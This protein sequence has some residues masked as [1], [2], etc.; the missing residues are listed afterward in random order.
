MQLEPS[1]PDPDQSRRVELILEQLDA[2]PTLSAV[3]VQV[4]ELTSDESSEMREVIDVISSDP[5]LASKVLKLCRCSEKGRLANVTTIDRAVVLLGF[6]SV[7]SAVLSV[8]VFELLEGV[9]S[10][11]GELYSQRAVFDRHL[12]WQHSLAVAITAERLC[13][14]SPLRKQIQPGEAFICGLLHDLGQLCLHLIL[15]KSFDR[16]CEL[17]VAQN[18]PLDQACLQTLGVDTHT[19]SRRVAELWQLPQQLSDVMWLNGQLYESLPQLDHR[20]LVGLIS[21]A[22]A[23]VRREH[24]APLGHSG[25]DNDLEALCRPLDVPF[26]MINDLVP[27]LREELELRSTSLGLNSELC[28]QQLLRSI[29]RANE[30]LGRTN[31]LLRAKSESAEKQART[32][33]A[34]ATFHDSAAPGGS[35]VSI[36]SRVVQSATRLFGEG[37]YSTLYQANLC[38]PWQLYQFD[39]DGRLQHS[40]IAIPADS[41]R[42]GEPP[43]DNLQ[44][45]TQMMNLLH[46]IEKS[47]ADS[48]DLQSVRILPLRCG[49]GVNAVLLHNN[50]IDMEEDRISLEA[51]CRTWGSAIAAGTQHEG[52]KRLGEQLVQANRELVEAQDHLAQVKTMAALGQLASGAAHEMNNPLTV[53]SG[54][55]QMLLNTLIDPQHQTMARQI[56]MQAHRLSDIITALRLFADPTRP[57]NQPVKM[58]D[59]VSKVLNHVKPPKRKD[60]QVSTVFGSDIPETVL[61][62]S[63]QI[64]RA[65]SELLKNAMESE[66]STHVELRIQIDPHNDRL[67][68]QVTDDGSGLA[69]YTLAHAFDPFFS[70]KPAGRQPGL[71]LSQAQRLVEARG[72]QITLENGSKKGAVATIWLPLSTTMK[73]R[74]VA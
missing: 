18:I 27:E 39:G 23:V 65:L 8:Q 29:S 52:A 12:F 10:S 19:A 5:A 42:T 69:P 64:E 51:L 56:A 71:G 68:L 24:I 58:S 66:G 20:K 72:G 1:Q 28:L 32:L 14:H 55:S 16:V 38:E 60:I 46:S 45:S 74:E 61:L 4:L 62:D 3:A 63:E 34:I 35:V 37:F 59:L 7:R 43:T 48:I 2:L 13:K 22:D 50:E 30:V 33:D 70:A 21:L 67:K 47:L 49:W 17:A 44:V 11:G 26:K 54:R 41:T 57:N 15:P 53:I 73:R 9:V 40:Q 31:V 36:L 25:R 6:D